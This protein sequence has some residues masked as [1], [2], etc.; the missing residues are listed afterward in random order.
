MTKKEFQPKKLA[1][2]NTKN[3]MLDAYQTLVDQLEESKK[4]EQKP[5]EKILE[6]ETK[7]TIETADTLSSESIA[8][9]ISDLKFNLSKTLSELS[10]KLENEFGK[11]ENVKKAVIAKEKELQEIYEIQKAASSLDALLEAEHQKKAEYEE[12]MESLKEDLENEIKS[13]KVDWDKEKKLHLEEIKERDLLVKKTF[14]RQK[15]EFDYN[16]NLDK[17]QTLDKF[18][19]EKAALQREL[20]KL[21]EDTVKDLSE[22]E[23][24]IKENEEELADLRKRVASFPKELETAVNKS[25]KEATEKII[26]ENNFKESLMKK[27]YEGERNVLMTKIESLEQKIES[28]NE[29]IQKL[30]TQIEKSYNQVQ[31][32]AIKAVEGPK[33]GNYYPGLHQQSD[34]GKKPN[35]D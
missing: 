20:A 7:K 4:T 9:N 2:T 33:Q 14:D 18:A 16:F 13:I 5:E 11:Y 34:S 8:K 32:I 26:M 15:E 1:M 23:K 28:Q 30:N 10:E 19:A 17:K 22:R 24:V 25:I 21:K 27:G 29:T 35:A 12:E 31:D 6:K 3:E